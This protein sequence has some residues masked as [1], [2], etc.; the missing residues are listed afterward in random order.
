MYKSYVEETEFKDNHRSVVSSGSGS[1]QG[2]LSESIA[3]LSSIPDASLTYFLSSGS[4]K[5][6]EENSKS[7]RN[8]YKNSFCIESRPSKSALKSESSGQIEKK[9][10]IVESNNQDFFYSIESPLASPRSLSIDSFASGELDAEDL[11][12][13]KI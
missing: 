8:K 1:G 13:I 7:T 3:S 11:K 12:L 9:T 2:A 10:R 6:L 4:E 5:S